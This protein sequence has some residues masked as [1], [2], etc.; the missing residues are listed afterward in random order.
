M[1]PLV[2]L[3]TIRLCASVIALIT[4]KGLLASVCPHVT[5]QSIG[6]GGRVVSLVALVWLLPSMPHHVPS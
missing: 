5:L 3:Q 1:R 4:L 2:T 6:R